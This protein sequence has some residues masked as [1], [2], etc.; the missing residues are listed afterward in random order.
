M[1]PLSHNTNFI[2]P[3]IKRQLLQHVLVIRGLL[4]AGFIICVFILGVLLIPP[5]GTVVKKI[6]VG[7]KMVT[8]FFT[9]PLYNL[10]NY[11]GQTNVLLLGMGGGTHEGAE[12]TDT[13]IFA[14]LDLKH[15]NVTMLSIPRD[16]WV[17]SLKAK[18]NAAYVMEK[19]R[20]L[21]VAIL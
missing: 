7:P 13:M 2:V 14:S 1:I 10:P 9:D 15:T 5:L 6:W 8:T 20:R 17:T 12:L 19:N 21:E 16:I 4:I 3:R 11:G 18:I